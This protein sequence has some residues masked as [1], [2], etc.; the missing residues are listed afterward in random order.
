LVCRK[1][2]GVGLSEV[3][4]ECVRKRAEVVKAERPTHRE[5]NMSVHVAA[6]VECQEVALFWHD[7]QRVEPVVRSNENM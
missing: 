5:A 1:P 6:H 7:A 4:Y 2:T 3:S